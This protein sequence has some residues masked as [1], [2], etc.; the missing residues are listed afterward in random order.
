M[1]HQFSDRFRV[2]AGGEY[3]KNDG[4]GSQFGVRVSATFLLGPNTRLTADAR[5]RRST[6][7]VSANRGLRNRV[8][9]WGYDV[10]LEQRQGD[11]FADATLQYR[12][13]RFDS[14]LFVQSSG[15]SFGAI[16][17]DRRAQLQLSTA[18]AFA[19]GT[20]GIGRTI[21]DGFAVVKSAEGI[22]GEVIVGNNLNN[23]EYQGRS[24]LLGA[25]VVPDILGYQTR[26]IV[27]DIDSYDTIFDVG[28][29]TDRVRIAT[30]G[31]VKIVVG[32]ER[33]VSTV[34]TLVADGKPASLVSGTVT[35]PTTKVWSPCNSS[36]IPPEDFRS[37]AW[38]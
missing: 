33:F 37:S 3:G 15:D 6:Y 7:R 35:S 31:G 25:A 19:D 32:S 38:R 16:T 22:D 26:E 14:R 13:N 24:G 30:N 28:E 2:T 27:Y 12:G 18:L 10:S 5:S 20:F 9:G 23:G 21:T 17:D 11:A 4:F 34:G 36:P 29:G 8:G 1:I